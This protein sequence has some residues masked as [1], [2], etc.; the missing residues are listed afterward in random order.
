MVS[1]FKI[2]L[3]S[4]YDHAFRGG[5]ADHINNL[6]AQF[7]A[8]GNTVRVIAPCSNPAAADGDPDFIPMGRSVALPAG[9]S[10][11]RVS[12]SVWLR[13]RIKELLSREAFDV[14][15][16]HEP[17]AGFTTFC[18]L[19][20]SDSIDAVKVGTFHSNNG[21][22]LYK[23]GVGRLARRYCER[24][25]GRIAVSE[26]AE[27]FA[28]RNLLGSYKVIPNGIDVDEFS[29][30]PPFPHLRDGKINLLFVGRIEKKKGLK[31]L[32]AA[33]SRLKWD[34]PDLRLVVVG[35]GKPDDDCYRIMSERNLQDVIFAGNVSDEDKARYFKTAD[36]FC[37][38]STGRESFGIVLAEAMAAGKPIVASDVEGYS[39]V[40]ENGREGI[41][42]PPKSDEEIA[43]AVAA[44]LADPGLR[45][46][47]AADGRR[48]VERF[49][50]PRVAEQVSD[51][52]SGLMESRLTAIA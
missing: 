8:W 7:R 10:I 4:P 9:G 28:K 50:W 12:L 29:D 5:V 22:R 39:S 49:R 48:R 16:L 31:Y 44:L 18:V 51:Y 38:P 46:R 43:H 34:W 41:L 37:S 17:F 14:V 13:P 47:M 1:P 6:A 15:H 27:R 36:I 24:L 11:A 40:I 19:A 23:T 2:A 45:S 26:A 25:D 52:Y 42:V 20:E 33:Y 21:T 30:A 35:P 3:V 32:L